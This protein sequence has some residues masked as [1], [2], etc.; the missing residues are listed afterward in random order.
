MED[1]KVVLK[2]LRGLVQKALRS[3]EDAPMWHYHINHIHDS[4]HNL[5]DY[6]ELSGK[7]YVSIMLA[8]G[9]F[10]KKKQAKDGILVKKDR[11]DSFLIECGLHTHLY[12]TK[13]KQLC[14]RK[15]YWIGL[16]EYT[17]VEKYDV[18]KQFQCM[19][20]ETES[21]TNRLITRSFM[22]EERKGPKKLTSILKYK[23]KSN[24]ENVPSNLRMLNRW[25]ND[26]VSSAEKDKENEYQQDETEDDT[27][28]NSSSTAALDEAA[29]G[30]TTY[31]WKNHNDEEELI[32]QKKYPILE[33]AGI[34]LWK[35]LLHG[36]IREIIGISRELKDEF[37]FGYQSHNGSFRACF[38]IP[39][40]RNNE[41][42]RKCAN[43]TIDK[44]MSNLVNMKKV[45]D[46]TAAIFDAGGF[47]DMDA[48]R[49]NIIEREK[50]WIIYRT[51]NY[52]AEKCETGFKRV[53]QKRGFTMDDIK[54]DEFT[55]MAMIHESNITTASLR[56]INRYITGT[57]GRR[58]MASERKIRNIVE[59]DNPPRI[60]VVD[61]GDEKHRFYVKDLTRV[62]KNTIAKRMQRTD[63][64]PKQLSNIDIVYS[65]DHGQAYF[66]TAVKIIL[67]YGAD[68]KSIEYTESLG[69]MKCKK[70]TYEL[71]IKT[72]GPSMNNGV[73]KVLLADGKTARDIIVCLTDNLVHVTIQGDD[74]A[75][76]INI[77]IDNAEH[78]I[79]CKPRFRITGDLAFYSL[80]V[81]KPSM[82]NKWCC[83]C[84]FFCAQDWEMGSDSDTE[85]W[86]KQKLKMMLERIQSGEKMTAQDR[87]GVKCKPIIDVDPSIIVIPPLHLKLGLFNRA[88]INPKGNSFWSWME[89][90][91]EMISD[92]ELNVRHQLLRREDDQKESKEA[93]QLW[94]MFHKDDMVEQLDNLR[95]LREEFK[96]PVRSGRHSPDERI[97]IDQ[98]IKELDISYK[99]LKKDRDELENDLKQKNTLVKAFK[100]RYEELK[101][102]RP[103]HSKRVRRVTE[104]IL[105]KWGIDRAAYHG[106]DLTG[107]PITKFCNY[108]SDIF[109]EIE[110]KLLRYVQDG[111]HKCLATAEEVT[112]VCQR[113][114]ELVLLL[115]GF[116]AIHMCTR[117][118]FTDQTEQ[119]AKK[120]VLVVQKR[121]RQ[122]RLSVK[123]PKY[124]SLSHFVDQLLRNKGLGSFNEQFVEVAH[125]VGNSDLRRVGAIKDEQKIAI[126][127]SKFNSSKSLPQVNAARNRL[128]PDR[129]RKVNEETVEAKKQQRHESLERAVSLI[130]SER[131]TVMEDYWNK[132]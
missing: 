41:T 81:G 21:M 116:F 59:D 26:I 44:I 43:P 30:D 35:S 132:R 96:F 27:D 108:A 32:V 73:Q 75:A 128:S 99:A 83:W 76:A 25:F 110:E 87:C 69:S 36:L 28:V 88:I 50:Q 89:C 5:S 86:T 62:I 42:F 119:L 11:C 31:Q 55:T 24:D 122:A 91:V 20:D 65:A 105:K 66:R 121:W 18:V 97:L 67:Y 61:V 8:L 23:N 82:D 16:G 106:G 109:H 98:E 37:E 58:I 1:K 100:K 72:M 123:G 117:T 57:L 130:E 14:E 60:E 22:N 54:M 63:H 51:I 13:V 107:N 6:L 114:K 38:I 2:M 48:V 77:N 101:N 92:D 111:E 125:K 93:L 80:I 34:P 19:T 56:V 39:Q 94:D 4:P 131:D 112:I 113:F 118:E 78:V 79:T 46:E 71:I 10:V 126:S 45:D 49:D 120:Y 17:G 85:E 84:K 129:K 64:D 40:V 70:D 29:L 7:E 33:R 103:I 102:A 53:G 90:R 104:E 124:H 12:Y 52:L 47:E 115:D 68:G 95:H 74:T 127:I 15:L 3:H 9:L